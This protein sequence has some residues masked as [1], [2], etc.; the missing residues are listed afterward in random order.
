MRMDSDASWSADDTEGVFRIDA[1]RNS[2]LYVRET[3]GTGGAVRFAKNGA[4]PDWRR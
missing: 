4:F 3:D 1:K 2:G